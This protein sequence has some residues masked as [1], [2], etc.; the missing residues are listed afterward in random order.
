MKEG[1]G[2]VV[3]IQD[4]RAPVFKALL[5]FVYTDALPEVSLLYALMQLSIRVYKGSNPGRTSQASPQ[6]I[7]T[8]QASTLF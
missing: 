4:I 3:D 6:V 2:G 5:H 8:A 1:Q 7:C